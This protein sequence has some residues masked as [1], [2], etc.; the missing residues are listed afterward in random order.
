MANG[1]PNPAGSPTPGGTIM[2]SNWNGRQRYDDTLDYLDSVSAELA[3]HVNQQLVGANKTTVGTALSLAGHK[4]YAVFGSKPVGRAVRALMLCHRAYF[5]TNWAKQTGAKGAGIAADYNA[6]GGATVTK[7][8][9]LNKAEA[10]VQGAIR[11]YLATT[12][13]TAALASAA[14]LVQNGA[15]GIIPRFETMTRSTRPFPSGQ[16]CFNC[17]YWWLFVS[18]FVSL[19]WILRNGLSLGAEN[20]NALLGLGTTLAR[21][22]TGLPDIPRGM[23]V[24]WRGSQEDT[25]DI[26]HWAV[27]LGDGYA[28]G[29]NNTLK[30]ISDRSVDPDPKRPLI[31]VDFRSGGSPFGVF[32]I[33]DMW[34]VY[35]GD[36]TFSNKAGRAG[37]VVAMIDPSTIPNR[38]TGL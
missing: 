18:G 37:C 20:S 7:D 31:D 32:S 27:S 34:N 38:N 1:P 4:M 2:S 6:P 13:G 21:A 35:D 28:I 25:A 8:A 30:G 17:V 36:K 5:G 3:N 12:P 29:A 15:T 24:N 33:A 19:R 9:Y 23:I 11:T 22:G 10:V 14:E 26:C 16:V